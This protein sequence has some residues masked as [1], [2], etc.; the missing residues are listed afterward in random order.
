V[1]G[2]ANAA[3]ARLLGRALRLPP[4]SITIVRGVAARHKLLRIQGL[5]AATLRE[6][7]ESGVASR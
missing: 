5:S 6:R 3:L 1:A 7:L 4:S 2:E